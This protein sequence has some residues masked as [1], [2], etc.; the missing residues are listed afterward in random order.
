ME[1]RQAK[2]AANDRQRQSKM[3][4]TK[5]KVA[6]LG[7]QVPWSK[8]AGLRAWVDDNMPEG[9]DVRR[10]ILSQGIVALG[11]A[12]WADA[13]LFVLRDLDSIPERFRWRAALSGVWLLSAGAARGEQGIFVKYSAAIHKAGRD[14]GRSVV[15]GLV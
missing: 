3:A 12:E 4:K 7:R 1:A 15:A 10:R 9:D 5:G 8:F 11:Q 6:M 13:D 2:D 14:A